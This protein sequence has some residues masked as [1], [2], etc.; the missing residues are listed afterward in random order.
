MLERRYTYLSFQQTALVTPLTLPPLLSFKFSAWTPLLCLS[1]YCRQSCSYLFSVTQVLTRFVMENELLLSDTLVHVA[2]VEC[3]EDL[4]W[5][6]LLSLQNSYIV[7]ICGHLFHLYFITS[8]VETASLNNIRSS[9][10]NCAVCYYLNKHIVDSALEL[11]FFV[12]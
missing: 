3:G 5:N 10:L 6:K 2:E 4:L 7:L 1:H 8:I 9:H 11:T 12:H